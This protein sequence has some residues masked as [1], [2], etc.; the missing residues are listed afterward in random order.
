MRGIRW[1]RNAKGRSVGRVGIALALAMPVGIAAAAGPAV[2][3]PAGAAPA[4]VRLAPAVAAHQPVVDG[5]PAAGGPAVVR[6]VPGQLDAAE[7]AVLNAG[8]TV[9]RRLSSLETLTVSLPAGAAQRVAADASVHSVTGNRKVQMLDYSG[10]SYS[11]LGDLGTYREIEQNVLGAA[12]YWNAGYTGKGVDVALIDSGTVAV[13]GLHTANKVVQGPDLSFES[14]NDNLRYQ[15]TYGHGTHM[16]GLI[17]GRDDNVYGAVRGGEQNFVGVAPDSRLVSVKVADASGATDVSQVLAAIDW[18]VTNRKTNGLNIRVLNLSFGTDSTQDYKIDPLAYAAEVA[19][20]SGI[21]V[22]AAAGNRGAGSER[23]TDPAYDPTILAVGAADN[24]MTPTTTDDSIPSYSSY[25]DATRNPDFVT[26]GTKMLSLRSPGSQLDME[27]PQAVF[28]NRLFR[29]SGTSQAAAVASGSVA[30]L[31]SQRP[32]LTP[33]QVKE[34]MVASA[35][36]LPNA[37][38]RGQGAGVLN[39]TTLKGLPTPSVADSAQP[40]APATGLG[41]LDASRGSTE[42]VDA[43]TG[44]ALTGEYD[45]FGAAWTPAI[46]APLSATGT[47]WSGGTWNGTRWS[48]DVW[49]GTRWSSVLWSGTRWSG[50]RWSGTRWSGADWTGTRWSGS[51]WT[52]T[53][54]SG[55]DFSGT[56]WSGTRWSGGTWS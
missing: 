22:V 28:Y 45:I 54:W 39:L 52:G 40:W 33:D 41:S 46:W 2:A 53:R 19:W 16:A 15:D 56:R 21:V 37:D 4:V 34:L 8:G 31:L 29:G 51:S 10:T 14:Q 12:S 6:A 42:L 49:S 3:A 18:V 1:G 20:R 9:V 44:E 5:V 23:L 26:Y 55:S 7:R 47:A 36:K 17:A 48:G 25:G 35:K 24:N 30:L 11:A 50:T 27:N 13:N 38:D 32:G 43:D